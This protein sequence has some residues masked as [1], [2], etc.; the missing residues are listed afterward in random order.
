VAHI[1]LTLRGHLTL[2]ELER[3]LAATRDQLGHRR[4]VVVDCREMSGYDTDA[5]ERFVTWHREHRHQIPR[6]AIV[7]ENRL[8]H[9]VVATMGLASGQR[10]KPFTTLAAASEWLRE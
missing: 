9:L 10:M 8:W 2:D 1:T 7:T 3:E 4:S 5:R 6:V